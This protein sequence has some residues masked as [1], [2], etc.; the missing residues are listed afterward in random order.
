MN[1]GTDFNKK[2]HQTVP[3]NMNKP[4]VTSKHQWK[5]LKF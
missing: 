2:T 5:V 1:K 4:N 3:H